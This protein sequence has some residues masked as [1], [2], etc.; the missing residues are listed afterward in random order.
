MYYVI[1]SENTGFVRD[2]LPVAPCRPGVPG[3]PAGP[4]LPGNPGRPRSPTLPEDPGK[5]AKKEIREEKR[6]NVSPLTM[7]ITEHSSEG[8]KAEFMK[9]RLALILS[10]SVQEYI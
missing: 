7:S 9:Y 6:P 10:Y 5:P 3:N 2:H 8:L 1:M 4:A